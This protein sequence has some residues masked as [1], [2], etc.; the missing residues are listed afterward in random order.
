MSEPRLTEILIEERAIQARVRDLPAGIRRDF[1]DDLHLICV[2]KAAAVTAEAP[3]RSDE[4]AH[5][6]PGLYHPDPRDRVELDSH[7]V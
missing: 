4:G 1:P 3:A 5:T 6:P 7:R 2:L